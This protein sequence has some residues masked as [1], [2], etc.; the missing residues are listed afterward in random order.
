ML[1]SM[2]EQLDVFVKEAEN[3]VLASQARLRTRNTCGAYHPPTTTHLRHVSSQ[4]NYH[5][6]IILQ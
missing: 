2:Y 4:L 6:F 1:G 5:M 3:R